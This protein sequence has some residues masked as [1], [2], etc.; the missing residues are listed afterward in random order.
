MNAAGIF[1]T[2]QPEYA[3]HGIATFPLKA[4]KTPAMTNYNKLGIKGS[5]E[6]ASKPQFARACAMGFMTNARNRIAVLDIDTPDERVLADALGRHGNTP[7]IVRTASGKHHAWYKYN[8]ERRR[9]RPFD[10]L[11][12]DLLGAG[13]LVVAPPSEARGSGYRFIEGGLDDIDR[14]P[15]M[16]GLE[17]DSYVGHK[18]VP[19]VVPD[20]WSNNWDEVASAGAVPE[21]Q[22]TKILLRA[23]LE[24]APL[25][26]DLNAMLNF[27]RKYNTERCAPPTTDEI[28]V[29]TATS[30]WGYETRDLNRVGRTGAWVSTDEVKSLVAEPDVLVLLMFLRAYQGPEATFMVAN[31]LAEGASARLA[32]TLPRLRIARRRLIE[33]GYVHCVRSAGGRDKLPAL[34]RWSERPRI[35]R[36]LSQGASASPASAAQGV[37]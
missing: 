2:W 21:G 9:I 22:R 28:V 7:I 11:P 37:S 34:F 24:Q 16:R 13:G 26:E 3:A 5:T 1:S 19:A 14:L 10:G 33:L 32:M 4:D 25:C 15:V 20:D 12:I 17:Q 23:C 29:K 27:A 35:K 6:I 30:A 18:N 36:A 31:G 8:G